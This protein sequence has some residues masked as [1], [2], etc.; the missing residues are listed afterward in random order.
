[1]HLFPFTFGFWICI[2]DKDTKTGLKVNK[3]TKRGGVKPQEKTL[4]IYFKNFLW[5][6]RV[7]N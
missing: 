4:L 5:N 3:D 2:S 1:M 6:L 7:V